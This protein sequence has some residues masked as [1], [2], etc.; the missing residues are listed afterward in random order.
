MKRRRVPGMRNGRTLYLLPPVPDD[1]PE[2]VKNALAIRNAASVNGICPS[3]G[4]RG[5][6][7]GPDEHGFFHLTFHHEARCGALRDED[8]A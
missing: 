4:A 8:T 6:L 7:N 3:C 5:E 1:A 2:C